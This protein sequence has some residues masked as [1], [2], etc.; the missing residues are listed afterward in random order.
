MFNF[1]STSV[2][3]VVVHLV[4]QVSALTQTHVAKR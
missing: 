3:I 2:G 4:I 1:F